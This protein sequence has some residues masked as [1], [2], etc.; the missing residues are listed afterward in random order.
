MNSVIYLCAILLDIYLECVIA[1]GIADTEIYFPHG[2]SSK[3]LQL[4]CFDH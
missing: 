1:T 2:E 4:A 3:Y